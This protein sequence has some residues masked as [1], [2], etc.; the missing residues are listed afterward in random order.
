M[1]QMPVATC[2]V[3]EQFFTEHGGTD[4]T[5]LRDHW[6]RF[7]STRERVLANKP[8]APGTRILDVGAH[9]LHQGALF[10][11][12]GHEV[13]ALDMPQ[14]FDMPFVQSA[15]AAL[16]ITLLVNEDLE[17]M[18]AL[19]SIPD[20]HYDLMLVTEVIEH[21]TFNPVA[22]W[23]ELYRVL[24]PGGRIIVT[25][26]NYYALRGRAWRPLRFVRGGGGGLRVAD[27]LGLRTYAHHW[28]EFSLPELKE[29]FRILSS[30]F[31]F[32]DARMLEA[33][34]ETHPGASV[35]KLARM[36]ERLFPFLRPVLYLEVGLG[37][38]RHGIAVTPHW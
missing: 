9:W 3:L 25:T 33:Y 11:L 19:Q 1:P 34:E 35:R 16:G 12:D 18:P 5:Y 29:Y 14:T 7:A 6:T 26:P 23:Q 32:P 28:K 22:M 38:K 4:F 20:S 15:A 8:L 2:D 24:K 21:L 17:T 10:A 31:S 37:S 13:H 30:D 27:I 36:I